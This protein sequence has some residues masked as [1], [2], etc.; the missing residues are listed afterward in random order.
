MVFDFDLNKTLQK[1][2]KRLKKKNPKLVE[3]VKK[4][5]KEIVRHDLETIDHYKNL[6]S[7][8]K[9]FKRVH[10]AKNFVLTFRVF[11]NKNLIHF[12]LLKHHDD[13]YKN[14]K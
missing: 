10:I 1:E 7:D 11:K 14:K 13:V 8:L 9:Q 3:V 12:E 4:K 2:L 5:I 6:R